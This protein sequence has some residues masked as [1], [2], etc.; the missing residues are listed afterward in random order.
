MQKTIQE[1]CLHCKKLIKIKYV[2]ALGE[3]SQKNNWGYWTESKETEKVW[4]CDD[5]LVLLYRQHKW[6]FQKLITNKKK[7][8]LFRQYIANGTI[9]GKPERLFIINRTS[10]SSCCSHC[11]KKKKTVRGENNSEWKNFV[12]ENSLSVIN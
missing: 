12:G 2:R 5:C 8:T 3:Y 4:A 7:Q 10:G 9:K 11:P 6:E 1:N